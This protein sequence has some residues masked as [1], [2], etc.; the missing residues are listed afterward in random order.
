MFVMLIFVCYL[1]FVFF[2]VSTI[3][4]FFWKCNTTKIIIYKSKAHPKVLLE[5]AKR[6]N[7]IKKLLCAIKTFST[8]CINHAFGSYQKIPSL[9]NG[10]ASLDIA[11]VKHI[12]VFKAPL[13]RNWST[14]HTSI[15]FSRRTNFFFPFCDFTHSDLFSVEL[16][17]KIFVTAAN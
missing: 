16:Q 17:H 7:C 14:R 9:L 10:F 5:K 2:G 8:E 12:P 13:Q 3:C 15:I 11:K 1:C 4:A 6:R